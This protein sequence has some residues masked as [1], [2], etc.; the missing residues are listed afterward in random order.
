MMAVSLLVLTPPFIAVGIGLPGW[1]L[2]VDFPEWEKP[3]A[4]LRTKKSPPN[5]P[6]RDINPIL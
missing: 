3:Q 6:R 2:K 4:I 5:P 1:P